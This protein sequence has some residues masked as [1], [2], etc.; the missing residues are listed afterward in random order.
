MQMAI[1][2]TPE[3]RL[4]NAKARAMATPLRLQ[5]EVIVTTIMLQ[6]IQQLLRFAMGLTITVT[7]KLTKV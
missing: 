5:A 3:M 2:I 4:H 6:F 1:C 7:T